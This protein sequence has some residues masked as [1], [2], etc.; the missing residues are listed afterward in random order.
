[1]L[2]DNADWFPRIVLQKWHVSIYKG[3][4]RNQDPCQAG[5]QTDPTQVSAYSDVKRRLIWYGGR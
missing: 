2:M 3:Q 5:Y 1:M 4:I